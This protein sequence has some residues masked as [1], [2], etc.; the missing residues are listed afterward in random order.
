M[1]AALGSMTSSASASDWWRLTPT[2]VGAL[3]VAFGLP[4]QPGA[5]LPLVDAPSA[6]NAVLAEVGV[7][8]DP[9]TIA[10]LRALAS[11]VAVAQVLVQPV[12]P[13]RVRRVTIGVGNDG[14]W[15]AVLVGIRDLEVA[16]AGGVA[17]LVALVLRR[18]GVQGDVAWDALGRFSA[19]EV[20]ALLA[21]TDAL[22]EVMLQQRLARQGYGAAPQLRLDA[23]QRQVAM[24]Q[25]Q[26]DPSWLVA[27]AGWLLPGG[28]VAD[29]A[30][31]GQG[32]AQLERAGWLTDG[33]P[34]VGRPARLWSV[35]GGVERVVQ[36]RWSAD[37]PVASIG[38]LAAGAAN[39][40]LSWPAAPGAP[41]WAAIAGSADLVR[42]VSELLT[43]GPGAG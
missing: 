18:V 38:I 7:P 14:A 39:L 40:L 16:V 17:E 36:V 26:P 21:G 20:T 9:G 2:Q 28:L 41:A 19:A 1:M 27:A 22:T 3:R 35:L 11:P 32:L 15:G 10:G 4:P 43:A 25:Q 23:V 33:L 12:G 42:S 31:L 30:V 37:G 13:G 8:S 24:G 29:A 5:P 34:E 6:P